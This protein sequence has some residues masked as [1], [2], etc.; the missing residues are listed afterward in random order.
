MIMQCLN[1]LL[2]SHRGSGVHS[3]HSSST[4]HSTTY[5][6]G[7]IANG[8]EDHNNDR[9]HLTI[10]RGPPQYDSRPVD[11]GRL[12]NDTGTSHT[13]EGD[14]ST[15]SDVLRMTYGLLPTTGGA[16]PRT[17]LAASVPQ[18]NEYSL[19]TKAVTLSMAKTVSLTTTTTT[20]RHVSQGRIYCGICV[21]ECD[22]SLNVQKEV[23]KNGESSFC[24]FK[25]QP[26]SYQRQILNVLFLNVSFSSVFL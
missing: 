21:D 4:G 7:R 15:I 6:R 19:Q 13:T 9:G 17:G 26:N 10:D 2:H 14:N 5:H 22:G 18:T 24:S 3:E 23:V 20:V 16:S 12:Q 8:R 1:A 11:R 25:E